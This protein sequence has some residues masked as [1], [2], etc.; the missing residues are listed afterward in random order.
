MKPSIALQGNRAAIRRIVAERRAANVRVFGSVLHGL[1]TEQSDLDLLV[2][3]T[4]QTSL[5]DL[6]GI[7][8]DVEKL[9]GVKVDVRTPMELPEKFRATVVAEAEPV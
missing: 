9:L 1:D 3:P 2:D 6:G 8:G 4:P 7:Q 5:F